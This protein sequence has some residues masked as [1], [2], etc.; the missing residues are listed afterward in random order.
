MDELFVVVEMLANDVPLAERYKNHLLRG[1]YTGY[2]ECH[3]APD[4]LLLYQKDVEIKIL[5]LY[6][7]GSHSDLF[8]KGKKR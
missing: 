8:G 3:I 5:S 2:W 1:D 6:R 4:W 7:T